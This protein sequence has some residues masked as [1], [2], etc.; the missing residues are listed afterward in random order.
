M[1]PWD[2]TH[3]ST[4][5]EIFTYKYGYTKDGIMGVLHKKLVG[6]MENTSFGNIPVLQSFTF[7]YDG[8]G[9]PQI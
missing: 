6:T 5:R 8:T 3:T 7:N 2:S 1:L 9:M 4:A